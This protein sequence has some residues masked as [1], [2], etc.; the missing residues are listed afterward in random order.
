MPKYMT[1][2]ET[3]DFSP[4]AH[5]RGGALLSQ[6]VYGCPRH[7]LMLVTWSLF[8]LG[9]QTP[10]AGSSLLNQMS[11]AFTQ[12]SSPFMSPETELNVQS[13]VTVTA[14]EIFKRS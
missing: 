7:S 9:F 6:L 8:I 11:A 4:A 2:L 10:I 12:F 3:L 1:S 13:L 14:N 5:L